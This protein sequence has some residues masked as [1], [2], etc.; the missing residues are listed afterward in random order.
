MTAELEAGHPVAHVAWKGGDY[1]A[2][3][4]CGWRSDPQPRVEALPLRC[5]AAYELRMRGDY[6]TVR[7][8]LGAQRTYRLWPLKG[9]AEMVR[10][11]GASGTPARYEHAA[12]DAPLRLVL[13]DGRSFLV[14]LRTCDGCGKAIDGYGVHDGRGKLFCDVDCRT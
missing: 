9:L 2:S 5:G 3:C 10:A 11:P 12:Q 8:P 6:A 1:V 13:E 7:T 4:A 14:E